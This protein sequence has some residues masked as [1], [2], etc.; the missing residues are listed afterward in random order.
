MNAGK[1]SRTRL[2]SS[3]R[4]A[5]AF[6]SSGTLVGC[7]LAVLGFALLLSL[8]PD[9][10]ATAAAPGRPPNFI[11]IFADNLGY[12]DIGPFG[13]KVHR[14]P[15]L[16]RMAAEGTRFT[17]FYVSAGVCTPSR[18]SLMTGCYAQRVGLGDPKPDGPAL[19]R[20]TH[21]KHIGLVVLAAFGV[22]ADRAG[23]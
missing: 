12:G 15:N 5:C 6:S 7:G 2:V 20:G 8:L 18:A 16:D 19:P 23:R 21:M 13:S 22:V 3:A 11:L 17:H 10:Q 9:A 4:R 1:M 14:T